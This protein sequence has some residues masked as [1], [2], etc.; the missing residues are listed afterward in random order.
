MR[1]SA[2]L[3]AVMCAFLVLSLI[4]P[5]SSLNSYFQN[6]FGRPKRSINKKPVLA[7]EAILIESNQDFENQGWPGNGSSVNP[8]RIENLTIA[9]DGKSCIV[10]KSTSVYFEIRNCTLLGSDDS[11]PAIQIWSS[12][13]AIIDSNIIDN[14]HH[15]MEL[16]FVGSSNIQN[17]SISANEIGIILRSST[18][19]SIVQNKFTNC[20]LVIHGGGTEYWIHDIS[21]N[22]VNEKPLIYVKDAPFQNLTELSI[23]QII[24]V[25][26]SYSTIYN[27]VIQHST[28]GV[29]VAYSS[30]IDISD[31]TVIDCYSDSVTVY[32]C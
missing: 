2:I 11:H 19:L 14:C 12:G 26:C 30:D 13:N 3:P 27:L 9:A 16:M 24:L 5:R 29:Q 4:P 15:G 1:I 10:I 28:A 6:D 32:N 22:L 8:Y 23:G 18:S 17:N 25:N 20:G 31:L 21:N 7:H